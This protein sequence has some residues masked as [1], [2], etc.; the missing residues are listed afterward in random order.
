[1][2]EGK[3]QFIDRD[4]V[5]F[6]SLLDTFEQLL[7]EKAFCREKIGVVKQSTLLDNVASSITV[8]LTR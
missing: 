4:S 2:G 3:Q 1:L 6:I 5:G 7:D 8:I